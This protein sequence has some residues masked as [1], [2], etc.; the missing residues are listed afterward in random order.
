MFLSAE[1]P[2]QRYNNISHDGGHSGRGYSRNELPRRQLCWRHSR[3]IT[4]LRILMNL[5][6]VKIINVG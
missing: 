4:L 2:A 5:W 3:L 6:W 1:I